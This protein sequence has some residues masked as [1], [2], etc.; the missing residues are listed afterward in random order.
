MA[1]TPGN[2]IEQ[3]MLLLLAAADDFHA[4]SP[5]P[6]MSG[7]KRSLPD[8]DQNGEDTAAEDEGEPGNGNRA[9]SE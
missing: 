4:E 9:G 3:E 2:N 6:T 7:G 8:D 1:P 5:G